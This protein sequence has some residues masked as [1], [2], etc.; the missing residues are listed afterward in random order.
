M[1][2]ANVCISQKSE[3]EPCG[4]NISLVLQSLGLELFGGGCSAPTQPLRRHLQMII[5]LDMNIQSLLFDTPKKGSW[6]ISLKKLFFVFFFNINILYQQSHKNLCISSFYKKLTSLS[7][8][9]PCSCFIRVSDLLL[10]SL[11]IVRNRRAS[12]SQS[13]GAC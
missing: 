7:V 1:V 8:C 11:R 13:P 2:E 5:M 4:E 12:L 10:L 9:F 6:F 3:E